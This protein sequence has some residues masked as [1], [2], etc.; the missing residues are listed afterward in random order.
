MVVLFSLL[1]ASLL[2]LGSTLQHF[3]AQTATPDDAHGW[4]WRT[5]ASIFRN[6]TWL[7]GA[8]IDVAAY[9]FEV[10]ALSRGSLIVVQPI[11]STGIVAALPLSA[12]LFHIR[13]SPA[14]WLAGVAVAAGVAVFVIAADPHGQPHGPTGHWASAIAAITAAILAIIFA[15][16]RVGTGERRASLFALATGLTYGLTA[17]LTKQVVDRFPFGLVNLLETWTPYQLAFGALLGILLGQAAYRAGPLTASLPVVSISQRV[18]AIIL[19]IVIFGDRLALSTR[20]TAVTA[21]SAM[22]AI[23][24]IVVLCRPD[25]AIS[26]GSTTR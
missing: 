22:A 11:L 5:H 1:A 24:G 26:S 2:A 7:T 4:S 13:H 21:F 8:A 12:R 9:G 25:P 10:A 18:V 23:I 16:R 20:Q 3:G 15:A 6:R 19:S 14:R 17:A